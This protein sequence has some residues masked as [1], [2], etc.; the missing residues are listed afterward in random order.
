M[1]V[2]KMS[3]ASWLAAFAEPTRIEIV[4]ELATGNKS[5]TELSRNLRKEIVNVS[6]HLSV[7]REAGLVT[8]TKIGR[9]VVYTLNGFATDGKTL[10]LTGP[11]ASTFTTPV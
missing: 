11:D 8:D 2:P 9:F 6:H 1:A 10:T 7:M 3:V 4:K 5:V